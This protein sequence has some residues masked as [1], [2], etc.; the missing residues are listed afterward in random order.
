MGTEQA[1]TKEVE[2][3]GTTWLENNVLFQFYVHHVRAWQDSTI[4]CALMQISRKKENL[5]GW[6]H[7]F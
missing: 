1:A 5:P 4:S 6:I 3:I 7:I 2:F